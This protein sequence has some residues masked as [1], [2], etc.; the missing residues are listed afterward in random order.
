MDVVAVLDALGSSRA[1]L[2]SSDASKRLS[3]F[4]PNALRSHEVRA[5][6]VLARQLHSALL[7][8]LLVTA[9]VS[10]VVG[11]R[12]D[13]V[14]IAI[15]LA[16]SIGLGFANEYRAALAAQALHTQIRHRATVHREG[17]M[18][19]I[20]VPEL[21]PEAVVDLAVGAVV[22]AVLRVLDAVAL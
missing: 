19:A 11:E 10:F 9:V 16:A 4:G 22:P 17:T 1:G 18:M 13:A 7:A 14:I 8:L 21:V 3:E 2:S 15:I 6:S 20:D 5:W 12:A